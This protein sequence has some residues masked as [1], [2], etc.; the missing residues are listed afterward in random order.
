MAIVI[1][2]F[3]PT[4]AGAADGT[5][6]ANRAP[7]FNSGN[8][9]TVITGFAFNGSDALECRIGPGSYTNSQQ[10][11]SGLFTN[12]PA[13]ANYLLLHG[14]DSSG[15]RLA[16]PQWVSSQ[17]EWS[18]TNWPVMT[19]INLSLGSTA[20]RCLKM[21][22]YANGA[23]F[24]SLSY[25]DSCI[26]IN[27]YSSTSVHVIHAA[28]TISNSVL[29]C[30]GASYDRVV[31]TQATTRVLN[32]RVEGVTGTSGNRHGIALFAGTLEV[33]RCCVVGVGGDG[34]NNV[35]KVSKTTVIGA[36]G[37]GL[38]LVPSIDSCYV[39]NCGNGINANSATIWAAN[40]RV[41][42]SNTALASALNSPDILYTAAGSDAAELVNAAGGDY[43]IKSGSTY[44]GLG[45]GADEITTGG[46]GSYAYIS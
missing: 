29:R 10:L 22:G 23:A 24:T 4:G 42:N 9:S 15:E 43:R 31:R 19:G 27:T 16:Q 11:A 8:W 7:L 14:C 35:A 20:I 46:G 34:I 39:A 12:A 5:T 37:Y 1:R 32:C 30:T 45:I 40:T 28:G 26:L 38:A 33:E 3:G 13:G 2:Y 36:G 21:T 44:W 17:P 41:R 6:W 25:V 18:T